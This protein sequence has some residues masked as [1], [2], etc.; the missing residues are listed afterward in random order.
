MLSELASIANAS[1]PLKLAYQSLAYKPFLSL[2][3]MTG[4]AQ[5]NPQLAGIGWFP[6]NFRLYVLIKILVNYAAAVALEVRQPSAGGEP[7]VRFNFKNGT[8]EEFVTYNWLGGSGDVPLS[9]FVNHV[10]VRC[11]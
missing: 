1:D 6:T 8:G 7:V 5:Q 4:L 2:F 11:L 10:N 9:T 3:N